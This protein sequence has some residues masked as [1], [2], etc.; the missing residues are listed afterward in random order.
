MR[1]NQPT[2]PISTL[3][4]K[5]TPHTLSLNFCATKSPIFAPISMSFATLSRRVVTTFA[6]FWS[7]LYPVLERVIP[8]KCNTYT[9]TSTPKPNQF[10]TNSLSPAKYMDQKVLLSLISGTIAD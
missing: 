7:I 4:E 10:H 9:N 6:H 5:K 3:C 1:A 8:C 2:H